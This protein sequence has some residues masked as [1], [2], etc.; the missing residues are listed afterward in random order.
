[1]F[2]LGIEADAIKD[3]CDGRVFPGSRFV[4]DLIKGKILRARAEPVGHTTDGDI[5]VYFGQGKPEHA[6]KCSGRRVISKWGSGPTHVWQHGIWEVPS[7]YG[8]LIKAFYPISN[9]AEC[10]RIWATNEGL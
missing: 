7:K 6:G 1:M 3:K 4:A 5:V 8:S 2:A 10:Y 9:A